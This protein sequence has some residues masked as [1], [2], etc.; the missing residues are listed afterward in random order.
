MGHAVFKDL[1]SSAGAEALSPPARR[2]VAPAAGTY[3]TGVHGQE[4]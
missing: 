1:G 2:E 3:G 4:R